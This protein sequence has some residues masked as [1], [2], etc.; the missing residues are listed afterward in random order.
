M[1]ETRIEIPVTGMTCANCAAT[2]ERTLLKKTPGVRAA[3]VNFATGRAS[4]VY[5]SGET[6]LKELVGAIDKAGF[7]VAK[8]EIGLA[9]TGMTCANCAATVERTL[10][11]KV[12]GVLAASVNFATERARVE[13]LP[14]AVLPEDMAAAVAKAGFGASPVEGDEARDQE[15]LAREAEIRNQTRK[16]LTGLVFAL[17]LFLAGMGRDFGLLPHWAHAA[18]VNWVF[19]ALAT[20][21]QFYT[22]FDYY[23]G[24]WKNLR[25]K[26][27]NMDVLV[28]L[29]SSTAY[30]YSLAVLLV[31]ALGGHVYFETSAVIITLIK[32]GKMLE[33]RTKGRTG[34]AI[35]KL[36]ALR[37]R[38]A[39]VLR[40]G[41]EMEVPVAQVLRG[42]KVV[43]KPGQSVPVDGEVTEG[44]SSV[45]ESMLTGESLPVD[46]RPGDMVAGGAL[47]VHGRFVFT[48][49]RV[50]RDTALANII[51]MVE[52]AQGHK[53][54]V[55]AVA[56]KV[57]AVFVPA[58][59]ALA[60]ITFAVWLAAG[61]GFA[62]AMIRLVA[63]LV[64]ACP[65]AL[66]LATPTAIM[67]GT[68]RG[69][70]HGI[71]FR[72]GEALEKAARIDVAVL[73][74]TGTIT[75]GK[76]SVTDVEPLDSGL[77]GDALLALAATIEQGSAHPLAKAV[78]REAHN[79][80]LA[81]GPCEDFSAEGGRGVRGTSGGER[82]AVG[83]PDW[84]ATQGVNT[85]PLLEQAESLERQGRTVMGVARGNTALGLLALAD[86]IAPGSKEAVLE[87]R[88]LGIE[89]HMVTGDNIN[90]ARAVAGEAG[91]E[92]VMAGVLPGDKAELVQSLQA[93][94]RVVA[95]VGDGVNDAPALSRADVGIAIGAGTDVAIESGDVILA[96]AGLSGAPRAV[97]LARATTR[98]IRQNLFW[99][100]GYNVALIPIAAGVLAPFESL[101][102]MLRHL[103]PILAAL[104]MATSSLTVVGN[105]L[106]LYRS[107]G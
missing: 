51:R 25:N 70:E 3:A 85:G 50:G 68:G 13:Y 52:E 90:T 94:G 18:W 63:V 67:A 41:A 10:L 24:A 29:G 92:H 40:E 91:I 83:K 35:R 32:L 87:L 53:A 56:D 69:A 20:P 78:V 107:K 45:D 93:K 2:V 12:P 66:G 80:G 72:N 81:L 9:V 57:A 5:E 44:E 34:G 96:G 62:P 33:A 38:T 15:A 8:G 11:K 49:L 101:P 19:F 99:A 28:A 88:A 104:A 31:P 17:P 46:K 86:T 54:P 71:L 16:F 76:P 55:Q 105:S 42:D 65:C 48:A 30:F 89:V 37:P 61:A 58:V 74:K 47:N 98:A 106:R 23:R 36:M 73:D 75:L 21:V 59:I 7:G 27:A 84:L 39:I 82:V 97:R 43:V 77:D 22:G 64:I 14:G 6:G 79:R 4:V 1:A 95:M 26:T 60:F 100:F 103:H 102:E